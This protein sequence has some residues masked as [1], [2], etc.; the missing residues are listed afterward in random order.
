MVI[1]A[2]LFSVQLNAQRSAV[3]VDQTSMEPIQGAHVM[4]ENSKISFVSDAQGFVDFTAWSLRQNL[5]ITHLAYDTLRIAGYKLQSKSRVF[6]KPRLYELQPFSLNAK[7][8]ETVFHSNYHYVHDYE[9]LEDKLVLITFNRSLKK[10]AAVVLCSI[11]QKILFEME[12]GAEPIDL[13]K[14]Y[15]GELFLKTKHSLFRLPI[16]GDSIGIE[17]VNAE[18]YQFRINN[19]VDSLNNHVVFND[20]Q[21]YLPRM[22]YYAFD[23]HDSVFFKFKYLEN[24]VVNKMYRWEYYELPLE[25][26]RRARELAELIPNMDKKDVGAVFTGFHKTMYYKPVS[27]PLFVL[28]DSLFIFDHSKSML[29]KLKNFQTVDSLK[30]TY[31]KSER[32][33]RWKD[34]VLFDEAT[35]DFYGVFLK[36]G[37]YYLKGIST[38]MGGV[39]SEFKI[40]KQFTENLKVQNGYV[41]YLYKKASSPEKPFLY[42][43]LLSQSQ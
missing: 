16:F 9:I 22:N 8:L 29:Y 23:T 36:N 18:E 13:L 41:Y 35:R 12:I 33:F 2:I 24:E 3:L 25:E 21:E 14:D 1:S 7:S 10:D 39:L 30:I 43:E 26:K 28:N 34:K 6:L 37:Y 15:K 27:A 19:C 42:R 17:K 40:E 11:D 20:Y 32:Y 38:E 31:H 4:V 5:I